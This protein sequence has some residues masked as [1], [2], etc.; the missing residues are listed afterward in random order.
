MQAPKLMQL[1]FRRPASGPPSRR[2][3]EDL[4]G[5]IASMVREICLQSG[6]FPP[7]DVRHSAVEGESH[8]RLRTGPSAAHDLP[9]LLEIRV[10]VTP[11][12]PPDGLIVRLRGL[13][14]IGA[15]PHGIG[16]DAWQ[17]AY[18]GDVSAPAMRQKLDDLLHL[19]L[20]A[21]QNAGTSTSNP[22]LQL[23]PLE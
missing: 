12:D 19:A 6:A 20:D 11:L 22:L 10:A 18:S 17:P 2:L 23:P 4:G 13:A 15:V 14:A 21:A 1:L 3:L 9:S 7:I 16:A 5:M 8:V